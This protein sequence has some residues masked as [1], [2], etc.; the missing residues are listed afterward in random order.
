MAGRTEAQQSN[1]NCSSHA[2]D[3][4]TCC[5]PVVRDGGGKLFRETCTESKDS[6]IGSRIQSNV[7][8]FSF[9]PNGPSLS[10]SLSLSLSLSLQY[11]CKVQN[12]KKKKVTV[13]IS[14][15]GV[16]VCLK[17]KRRK[18]SPTDRIQFSRRISR[19]E[20]ARHC[21]ERSCRLNSGGV[22]RRTKPLTFHHRSS[23]L[24]CRESCQALAFLA[25]LMYYVPSPT[26]TAFLLLI[27]EKAAPM[28]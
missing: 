4:G 12:S 9:H 25:R 20:E 10:V 1:G 3:T 16:R 26:V 13:S 21:A 2:K 6:F 24:Y 22:N 8:V 11:E 15:E 17:R 19:L 14:V 7:S 27:A 5:A 28:E 18:V 23:T